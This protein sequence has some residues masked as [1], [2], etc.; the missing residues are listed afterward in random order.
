[1]K[2]LLFG[3]SLLAAAMAFGGAAN[4]TVIFFS[5]PG[6]DRYA[7][8]NQVMDGECY[9]LV[10]SKGT[11]AGIK[12]DCTPV[13]SEDAIV[14]VAPVAKGGKCPTIA[15]EVDADK[16]DTIYKGGTFSVCLLDTRVKNQVKQADG[17]YTVVTTL[18]ACKNGRPLVISAADSVM[19]QVNISGFGGSAIAGGAL[20]ASDKTQLPEGVASAPKISSIKTDDKNVYLTVQNAS[21]YVQ[22]GVVRG[23]N[24]SAL[25]ADDEAVN[26][27]NELIIVRPKQGDSGFFQLEAK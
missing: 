17:S 23:G 13:N 7:D 20:I 24:P 12:A 4:D 16:I 14:L 27:S 19:S 26:G 25:V 10:W 21:P 11:F 3:F 8:G 15:F 22:Y 18:S 9:A 5:T 1:M 6:I 2:K